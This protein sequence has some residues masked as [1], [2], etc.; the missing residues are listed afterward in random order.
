M[1]F[2]KCNL[3]NHQ[4]SQD[5]EH[6]ENPRERFLCPLSSQNAHSP[7]PTPGNH[8]S[9][10]SHS[11]SV[12]SVLSAF[13]WNWSVWALLSLVSFPLCAFRTHPCSLSFLLL[14]GF[15][16]KDK[17]PHVCLLSCWRTLGCFQFEVI[18][19]AAATSTVSHNFLVLAQRVYFKCH[20]EL[21]CKAGKS[22]KP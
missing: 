9:D 1:S 6:N 11:R 20:F 15:S 8:C 16:N 10:F 4:P 12:L 19:N 18:I 22:P 3:C 7:C 14:N 21:D 5:R 13:K 17:T 2:H